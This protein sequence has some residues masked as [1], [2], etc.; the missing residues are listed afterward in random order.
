MVDANEAWSPNEAVRRADAYRRAGFDIFW[1][2]D[3]CLRDDFEG[4]A[5]V[6]A[7]VPF[8]HIN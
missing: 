6:R 7:G 8:G 1:I 3:P 4:L 2:E 5:R